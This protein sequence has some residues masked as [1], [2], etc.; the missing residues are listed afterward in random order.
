[1]LLSFVEVRKIFIGI[2]FFYLS[3]KF[4]CFYLLL[5][6]KDSKALGNIP[7]ISLLI[8]IVTSFVII[9]FSMVNFNYLFKIFHE[10]VFANDY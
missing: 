10:I 8:T 1:M 3:V 5:I 4:A 7:V 6:K 9:A 2:L